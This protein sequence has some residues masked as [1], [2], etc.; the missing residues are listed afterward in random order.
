MSYSSFLTNGLHARNI[1]KHNLFIYYF[2]FYYINMFFF[3]DL[4]RLE[5]IIDRGK[6]TERVYISLGLMALDNKDFQSGE[7]CFRKALVVNTKFLL[8]L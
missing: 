4:Y 5:R 6:E 8:I 7:R 3:I 2:C 1:S